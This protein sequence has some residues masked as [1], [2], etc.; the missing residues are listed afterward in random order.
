VFPGNHVKLFN[1]ILTRN[2]LKIDREGNKRTAYSLRHTYISMRL[3]GARA[4]GRSRA[5]AAPASR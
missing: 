1:G 3:M 5:T 4:P 2:N